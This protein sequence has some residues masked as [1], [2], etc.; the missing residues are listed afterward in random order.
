M[1]ALNSCVCM[2]TIFIRTFG[3]QLMVK[4]SNVKESLIQT[5]AISMQLPLRDEITT[6][7]LPCIISLFPFPKNRK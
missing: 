2:A 3:M 5:E 7:H 4:N 6:S 1:K